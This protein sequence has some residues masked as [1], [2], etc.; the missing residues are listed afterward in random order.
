MTNVDLP[1]SQ[2]RILRLNDVMESDLHRDFI[3]GIEDFIV[4]G[5]HLYE[6]VLKEVIE[7]AAGTILGTKNYRSLEDKC[8]T[9]LEGIKDSKIFSENDRFNACR[10][11]INYILMNYANHL[12]EQSQPNQDLTS[13]TV[14]GD[15]T[16]KPPY[17]PTK[18]QAA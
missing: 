4:S 3:S 14:L 2:G 9:I 13:A 12:L 16:T 18:K 6:I 10:D 15:S 7:E 5:Q 11:G 1:N 8:E 17:T